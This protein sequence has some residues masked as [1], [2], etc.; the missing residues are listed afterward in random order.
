MNALWSFVISIVLG[1]VLGLL[2]AWFDKKDR[3]I[4]GIL[5]LVIVCLGSLV[6]IY[7]EMR[8]LRLDQTET[9]RGAVPI[10][11]SDV[12]KAVVKDVADYDRQEPDTSFTAILEDPVRKNIETSLNQATNGT[13]DVEDKGDVVRI[14]SELMDQARTSVEATSFVDPKEWWKSNIGDN[15]LTDMRKAK[16]HVPTFTRVFLLGS[17]DEARLLTSIFQAQRQIGVDVRYACAATIPQSLRRDFIVIDGVVAADLALD[18]ERHFEHASFYST[19]QI[20]GTLDRQ[21][22][23]LLYYASPYNPR[24]EVNCPTLSAE[25]SRKGRQ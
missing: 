20:A 8:Q 6:A 1:G 10:L 7:F 24:A 19:R 16:N 21:F 23:D 25:E 17:T 11:R 4:A 15:Y 2:S 9:L 5:G 12:W 18:Q 22:R 13:I 3:A 14:T